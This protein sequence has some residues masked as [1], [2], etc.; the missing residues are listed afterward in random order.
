[1]NNPLG[2]YYAYFSEAYSAA[3]GRFDW[4]ACIRL[5]GEAGFTCLE[6][7]GLRLAD[8]TAATRQEIARRAEGGG[9]T[10]TLAT[11]LPADGDLA[12]LEASERRS[13]IEFLKRSLEMAGQM[14]ANRVCGILYGLGGHFPPGV[15]ALRRQKLALSA[16]ALREVAP[17]AGDFGVVIGLEA[18]NRF[19]SPLVNTAAEA[20]ELAHQVGHP[21]V[22]VHLDTFHMN[23]EEDDMLAAIKLAA[24]QLVHFHVSENSRRLP[25]SGPLDWAGVFAALRAIRYPGAIVIETVP[26]VDNPLAERLRIWRRLAGPDSKQSLAQSARFLKRHLEEAEGAGHG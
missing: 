15:A 12:S 9:L 23:I 6:L 2:I 10:L 25:G 5:A 13:G 18:V 1:M 16:A 17:T 14:R 19:E 11:A 26:G 22:G 24:G 7:S 3:S 8:E 20:C 21:A 4:T